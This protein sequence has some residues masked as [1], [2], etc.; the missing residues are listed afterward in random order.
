MQATQGGGIRTMKPTGARTSISGRDVLDRAIPGNRILKEVSK[1]CLR[2]LGGGQTV[3][4]LVSA[5][6]AKVC[7]DS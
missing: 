7:E 1:E 6:D 5:V 4:K 3:G 2:R